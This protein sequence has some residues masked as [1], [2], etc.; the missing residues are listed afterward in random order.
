[1]SEPGRC[2]SCHYWQP[3]QEPVVWGECQRI[4][5]VWCFDSLNHVSDDE[6]LGYPWYTPAFTP[7]CAEQA[8]PDCGF[9]HT[10][11]A[12]GCVLWEAKTDE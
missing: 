2:G 4:G 12:F 1:M 6:S 7:D 11:A 9:L 10:L 5:N 3:P 8:R